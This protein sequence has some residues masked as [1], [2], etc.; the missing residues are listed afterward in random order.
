MSGLTVV[1]GN[2]A[3]GRLVTEALAARGGRV[4]VAQRRAPADLPPGVAFER[5]DVL[6]AADVRRAVEGASRVLLSVGFAYDARVWRTAWPTTMRNVVE[7]CAAVG[8]RV[9]FIDNLYQL[10]PQDAPRREDMALTDRG[11]KPGVLAETTR[12]WMAASARVRFAAL[13]CTDFYGPGVEVSHLGA[14]AL[15]EL[16]RGRSAQLIVPADIPHDFAYVPDIARAAVI[17]LDAPDDAYG[18]VWN[19]PCAP[20][21]TPRELLALAAAAIGARAGVMAIPF[22]LVS[23]SGLFVRFARE[24]TD[25]GFTWDRPYQVD[26]GKFAGRFA[27]APTPFEEGIPVAVRSFEAVRDAA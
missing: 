14:S 13:R 12:I 10:G 5:C 16:A 24:V 15:G 17:L 2:G 27:F 9:V 18:Q 4:K 1:F 7:A 6:N 23:L 22:W 26:G 25:V 11:G 19:M 21:R 8:A 20:T 3:V